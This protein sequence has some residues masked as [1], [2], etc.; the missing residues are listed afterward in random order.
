MPATVII[1]VYH[2]ASPGTP[3]ADVSGTTI[4]FKRAD[5]DLQDSNNPI[6]IPNSGANYSWRKSIKLRILT[7]PDTEIRNLRFY[8]EG[9]SLGTGRS[10][11]AKQASTYTQASSSDE[12]TELSGSVDVDTY[13]TSSPLVL[14]AGQVL[15]NGAAP[16]EGSQ[17]FVELQAKID[18]TAIAGGSA[19]AKGLVYRYDEL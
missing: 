3:S 2:G 5:E 11:R 16:G 7:D 10:L 12:G 6:P 4:R 19:N 17:D 8:S 1:A 18:S 14:E 13:T 9:Q 15:A